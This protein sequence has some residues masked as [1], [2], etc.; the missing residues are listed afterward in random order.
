MNKKQK[1]RKKAAPESAVQE[2]KVL[3]CLKSA[4]KPLNLAE[5]AAQFKCDPGI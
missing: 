5:L 3:S 4:S 1:K 2:K